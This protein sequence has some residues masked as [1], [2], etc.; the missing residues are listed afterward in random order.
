M[1]GA[2]ARCLE[3]VSNSCLRF[4]DNKAILI[5]LTLKGDPMWRYRVDELHPRARDSLPWGRCCWCDWQPMGMHV[6]DLII[7]L[8]LEGPCDEYLVPHASGKNAPPPADES[9]DERE[10][11][12]KGEE[13]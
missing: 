2:I 1:R 13:Y 3:D 5:L 8:R 12:D 9:T 7:H 6:M 11:T 10:A 4:E